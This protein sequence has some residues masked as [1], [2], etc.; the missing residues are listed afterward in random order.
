MSLL[1]NIITPTGQT[2]TYVEWLDVTTTSGNM[3][4]LENHAPLLAVIHP[5]STLSWKISDGA[6]EART[7]ENAIMHVGRTTIMIITDNT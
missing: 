4:I 7:V 6:V 1:L 3:V 5:N 2:K